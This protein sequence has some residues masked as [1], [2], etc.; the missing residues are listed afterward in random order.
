MK[1]TSCISQVSLRETHFLTEDT[2]NVCFHFEQE[3]LS[4]PAMNYHKILK[5]KVEN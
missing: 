3:S 2:H 4:T 1:I 5:M